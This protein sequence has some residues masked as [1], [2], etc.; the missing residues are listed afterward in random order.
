[1]YRQNPDSYLSET[2]VMMVMMMVMVMMVVLLMA[3]DSRCSMR[4]QRSGSRIYLIRKPTLD[5][6]GWPWN[7]LAQWMFSLAGTI[8]AT[9]RY[10]KP[11]SFLDMASA[12]AIMRRRDIYCSGW[13]LLTVNEYHAAESQSEMYFHDVRI[14]LR[15]SFSA[16]SFLHLQQHLSGRLYRAMTYWAGPF[17][18]RFLIRFDSRPKR[19][20]G[21]YAADYLSFACYNSL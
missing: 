15:C 13:T 16:A 12:T 6:T 7:L 1:M 20:W 19:D 3:D 14:D 9:V 5:L 2:T 17:L 4:R 18:Q 8:I 11:S 21:F 10:C